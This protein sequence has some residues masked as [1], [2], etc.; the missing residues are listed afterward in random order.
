M[1][2]RQSIPMSQFGRDHWST[3]AYLESRC[4]NHRGRPDRQHMRCDPERHPLHQN[5]GTH[6]GKTPSPT[7]LGNGNEVHEHDDWDCVDDLATAGLV[8]I[9]G[10]GIDPI[11]RLTEHGHKVA[12]ALRRHLATERRYATFQITPSPHTATKAPA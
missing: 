8:Q 12:A 2:P 5:R 3:F 11:W 1:T 7:R 9:E 4:V 6:T 10:S